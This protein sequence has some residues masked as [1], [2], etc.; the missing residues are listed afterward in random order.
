MHVIIIGAGIGGLIAAHTLLRAG[1][2]V[3]VFECSLRFDFQVL[4]RED[5]AC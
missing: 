2:T 5:P 1:F 4:L 3:Q